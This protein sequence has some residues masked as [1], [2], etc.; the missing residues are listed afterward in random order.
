MT[1][2]KLYIIENLLFQNVYNRNV[3]RNNNYFLII[4]LNFI[5]TQ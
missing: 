2:N 5:T 1:E 3:D 4:K